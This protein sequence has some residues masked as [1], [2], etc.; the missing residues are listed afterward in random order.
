MVIKQGPKASPWPFLAMIGMAGCFF[1][2]AVSGLLA[3]WYAVVLLMVIWVLLF[4]AATRWWTPHPA[5]TLVLPVI[6][7]ALWFVVLTAGEAL[8]GWTA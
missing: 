3:P 6:A 8:F 7:L 4:L 1:L 2:Y 5:R